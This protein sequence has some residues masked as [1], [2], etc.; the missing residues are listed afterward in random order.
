MTEADTIARADSPATVDSLAA[1]LRALGL[2]PGMTILVH[3][4]LSLLG[5][6]CGGPVAVILALEEVL[7]PEGTLVMPSHSSDL[8]EPARWQN[9]PVPESWWE[10]IR[11]TMPAFDP[12]LTPTRD[13]GRIAETFRK[14]PGVIRSGH[15][16]DSFAAWG[17]HAAAITEGHSLEYGLGEG[18]PLARIYDLDGYVLLLGV[19]HGNN[20]S[21]HLAEYR[22]NFAGKKIV[23][24]GAPIITATPA[25]RAERQWAEYQDLDYD[26]DD[27]W[28]VG[29]AFEKTGAARI[30]RVACAECRLLPQRAIVDFAVKWLERNRGK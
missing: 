2:A 11:R 23:T 15:P 3:S 30:G 6:V 29:E 22:A 24:N 5:W 1:D 26:A 16:G 18:S 7:T 17:K 9:P 14:Q 19:G 25:G 28:K 21:L 20:T 4:S 13:M 8:S 10:P 27:F 12:D